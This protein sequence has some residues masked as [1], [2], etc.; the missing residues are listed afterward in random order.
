[1]MF[2]LCLKKAIRRLIERNHP[3]WGLAIIQPC[4]QAKELVPHS[5]R[6]GAGSHI[7]GGAFDHLLSGVAVTFASSIV[8]LLR[9]THG[10]QDSRR[11]YA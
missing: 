10:M 4:S 7:A 2:T 6:R 8:V 9:S 3:A 5:L 1:M 11:I